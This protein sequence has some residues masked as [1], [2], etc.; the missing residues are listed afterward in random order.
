MSGGVDSAV[1]AY[2]IKTSVGSAAGATMKLSD[3]G[4]NEAA[5]AAETARRLGIEHYVLDFSAEFSREVIDRFCSTYL[6]G[7]TP[8]P[9]IY[10]NRK[11]K[12]GASLERALELGYDKVATG[13]YAQIE[14]D[15]ESGRY[16][17]LRALDRAKDQSYVL[18][19][20]NQHQ[21]SKT[22][23]PLGDMTKPQ[24][25]A[26]AAE[27]G[28]GVSRA[29]RESGHLLYPRPRPRALY[30]R[31]HRQHPAAR[32]NLSIP[33]AMSSASIRGSSTTR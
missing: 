1:A 11:I 26:L 25:R 27:L 22:L 24:V 5:S 4:A 16:I 23:L 9:C 29:T 15:K 30:S 28:L 12:F 33:T 3:S 17:L 10:C 21:L 31:A 2:L 19:V 20:L 14:Y 32:A 18:S 8:N 7:A 6:H 13:H